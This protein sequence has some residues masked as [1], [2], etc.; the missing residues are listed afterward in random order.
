MPAARATCR[1]LADRLRGFVEEEGADSQE[2]DEASLNVI[3]FIGRLASIA[4]ESSSLLPDLAFGRTRVQSSVDSQSEFDDV[5][6]AS[7][8]RWRKASVRKALKEFGPISKD[9]W[10][11]VPLASASG[12]P[13]QPSAALVQSLLSL[14][15]SVVRLGVASTQRGHDDVVT[16]L[17]LE[18]QAAMTEALSL[19]ETFDDKVAAQAL[20]DVQFIAAMTSKTAS[21]KGNKLAGLA[22]RLLEAVASSSS[23]PAEDLQAA[24]S[25]SISTQRQRTQVFFAPLLGTSSNKPEQLGFGAPTHAIDA[26]VGNPLD[27]VKPSPRFGLLL[28]GSSVPL[29]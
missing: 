2:L 12:I 23:R 11:Y 26:D 29:R 13:S 25:T 3:C 10:S 24:I 9:Q 8:A 20:W 5:H 21:K 16:G 4:S 22:D 17:L 6:R 19:V 27:V 1:R 14:K 7:L 15:Q 28:V 18:Y